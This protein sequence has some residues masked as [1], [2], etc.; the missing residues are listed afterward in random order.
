MDTLQRTERRFQDEAPGGRLAPVVG[1]R[2]VCD[3]LL[4]V[5]VALLGPALTALTLTLL[6][7]K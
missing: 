6:F 1:S 4:G 5:A 2:G 7:N 3:R